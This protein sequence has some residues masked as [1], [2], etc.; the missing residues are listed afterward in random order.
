MVWFTEYTPPVTETEVAVQLGTDWLDPHR[1]TVVAS[2]GALE[3][4]AESLVSGLID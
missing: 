2:S 4:P 1:R 3:L